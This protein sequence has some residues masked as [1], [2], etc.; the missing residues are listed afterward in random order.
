MA[1]HQQTEH[2]ARV[3]SDLEAKAAIGDRTA[4]LGLAGAYEHGSH[5]VEKNRELSKHWWKRWEN[6][7]ESRSNKLF[8]LRQDLLGA[9]FATPAAYAL[10]MYLRPHGH[11]LAA[12]FALGFAALGIVS[13]LSYCGR[14]LILQYQYV[15]QAHS[16][17]HDPFITDKNGNRYY[18]SVAVKRRLI[19]VAFLVGAIIGVS[20][21][22]YFNFVPAAALAVPA[23]IFG[24]WRWFDQ[25]S[26]LAEINRDQGYKSLDTAQI[27]GR[28]SGEG[29]ILAQQPHGH[30]YDEGTI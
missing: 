17:G 3:I 4:M 9:A 11:P 21:G 8:G 5:G 6:T 13:I 22:V 25:S 15:M 28:P 7:Q 14:Y 27:A 18:R 20:T 10:S 29:A 26:K 2:E 30:D 23:A 24:L 1:T 19:A 12:N 16:E